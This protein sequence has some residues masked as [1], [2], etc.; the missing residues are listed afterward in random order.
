MMQ[1][2]ARRELCRNRTSIWFN[3]LAFFFTRANLPNIDIWRPELQM[4]LNH[5]S[6]CRGKDGAR[7]SRAAN[8]ITD[9]TLMILVNNYGITYKVDKKKS[10]KNQWDI[11]KKY[12]GEKSTAF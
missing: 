9:E 11:E 4:Y 7:V 3:H 8:I 2:S 1:R 10:I 6:T 5:Y 12:M